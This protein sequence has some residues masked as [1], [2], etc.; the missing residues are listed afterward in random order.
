MLHR[1]AR[2]TARSRIGRPM[3]RLLPALRP[4]FNLLS[5]RKTPDL[6]EALPFMWLW[7]A[8]AASIVRALPQSLVA[9]RREVYRSPIGDSKSLSSGGPDLSSCRGESGDSLM[10]LSFMAGIIA[11]RPATDRGPS[12]DRP[13]RL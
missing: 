6:K 8:N 7:N 12:F 4:S 1:L 2:I 13:P 3:G 10:G 5:L 9:P 11:H